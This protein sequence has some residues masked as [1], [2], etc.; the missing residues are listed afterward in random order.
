MPHPPSIRESSVIKKLRENRFRKFPH[1]P[2]QTHSRTATP[3]LVQ[4]PLLQKNVRVE[5]TPPPRLLVTTEGMEQLALHTEE[6]MRVAAGGRRDS[7]RMTSQKLFAKRSLQAAAARYESQRAKPAF[8]DNAP[9]VRPHPLYSASSW[10]L[11]KSGGEFPAFLRAKIEVFENICV[12]HLSV[13]L[14]VSRSMIRPPHPDP[15]RGSVCT[16]L[17]EPLPGEIPVDDDSEQGDSGGNGPAAGVKKSTQADC[18]LSTEALSVLE[19]AFQDTP[20]AFRASVLVPGGVSKEGV[21]GERVSETCVQLPTGWTDESEG[22]TALSAR[23][24]GSGGGG[25]FLN[26]LFVHRL[27]RDGAESEDSQTET[28][29]ACCCIRL[30]SLFSDGLPSET[31]AVAIPSS[32]SLDASEEGDVFHV[33]LHFTLTLPSIPTAPLNPKTFSF[34]FG[35]LPPPPSDRPT[36]RS[37]KN[38]KGDKA[39]KYTNS[40]HQAPLSTPSL[41]DAETMEARQQSKWRIYFREIQFAP[42]SSLLAQPFDS[43]NPDRPPPGDFPA[44]CRDPRF[45]S[46]ALPPSSSSN[47]NRLPPSALALSAPPKDTTEEYALRELRAAKLDAA[48][49]PCTLPRRR[50]PTPC[51]CGKRLSP[52]EPHSTQCQA[53]FLRQTALQ[54]A[55]A[56]LA[57]Q[58]PSESSARRARRGMEASNR[59]YA[60]AKR[61]AKRAAEEAEAR[62]AGGIKT[63]RPPMSAPAAVCRSTRWK[64]K[65]KSGKTKE[66]GKDTDTAGENP[67][68]DPSKEEDRMVVAL[69]PQ[70]PETPEEENAKGEEEKSLL[71][72]DDQCAPPEGEAEQGA[73][74]NGNEGGQS[75]DQGE[76]EGEGEGVG[77]AENEGEGGGTFLTE[78]QDAEEE[79]EGN[80]QEPAEESHAEE[81]AAQADVS[82][83]ERE[84]EEQDQPEREETQIEGEEEVGEGGGQDASS[85]SHAENEEETEGGGKERE[86]TVE[87][88]GEDEQEV[89]EN[90]MNK[91]GQEEKTDLEEEGKA[92]SFAGQEETVEKGEDE[93]EE[94][95]EEQGPTDSQESPIESQENYES[96]HSGDPHNSSAI[97]S[98][99][100][101]EDSQ[102]ENGKE[103]P[104]TAAHESLQDALEKTPEGDSGDRTHPQSA[105]IEG[106]TNATGQSDHPNEAGGDAGET[107]GAAE[108]E[109]ENPVTPPADEG[110]GRHADEEGGTTRDA[111]VE[112]CEGEEDDEEE[113]EDIPIPPAGAISIIPD[114]PSTR[115][116]HPFWKWKDEDTLNQV[117][118]ESSGINE[119]GTRRQSR[120]GTE[121]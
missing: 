12:D 86:D 110:G 10:G 103:N 89:H 31:W 115:V 38:R 88:E 95:Q 63:P 21:E 87:K 105:E 52:G 33:Q 30:P 64:G 113:E 14:F 78:V 72:E 111:E 71:I 106:Q 107:Q 58:V 53:L 76:Q 70:V 91:V 104:G 29:A 79:K 90:G 84:K 75:E 48:G 80:A 50:R 6:A 2:K 109:A 26:A 47:S 60:V 37:S 4:D 61:L 100:V 34:P 98:E 77:E 96:V 40:Q 119:W 69:I 55:E 116:P 117:D 99:G 24:G 93:K 44:G 83:Q 43:L 101:Q 59:L 57:V 67:P 23:G 15:A 32:S 66:K 51:I 73:E 81:T 27:D 3:Q 65:G 68:K 41:R 112:E 62:R 85:P 35:A 19:K 121:G 36:S 45:L 22:F 97:E 42:P 82:N 92:L 9:A 28:V 25:G 20:P 8:L 114:D 39:K 11:G 1:L 17:S 74:T 102:K 46:L 56:L 16:S 118:R 5:L 120:N 13:K 49:S 108:V 94:G 7:Q 54:Q 18:I